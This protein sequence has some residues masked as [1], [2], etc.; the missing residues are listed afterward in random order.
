MTRERLTILFYATVYGSSGDPDSE[1]SRGCGSSVDPN[2]ADRDYPRSKFFGGIRT[3][4]DCRS[5]RKASSLND[6]RD[7]REANI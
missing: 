2:V 6:C 4:D 7:L 3:S 5:D 1:N